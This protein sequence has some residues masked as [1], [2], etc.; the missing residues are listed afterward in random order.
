MEN[1]KTLLVEE[2]R[3]KIIKI[4]SRRILFLVAM[5]VVIFVTMGYSFTVGTANLTPRESYEVLLGQLFPDHFPEYPP[6]YI[7][8]MMNLR[9]PRVL[10]GALVGAI[11][12]IGGCIMQSILKN[13]LATPYT[14]G[15]SSGAAVGASIYF[16]FGIS[17]FGGHA[18]LISN[19]FFFSLLP[20]C[21]MMFVLLRRT[22]SAVTLVLSGVAFSYVFSSANS[23]MQYFG[24][25]SAVAQVVFWTIGDLTSS[26]MWMVPVLFVG[27]V[28]YLAITW[29]LG[30]DMD[31]MRM[32]DDTAASLGINVNLVRGLA[33]VVACFMTALA[34]ACAGPIGFVCLLAPHI[35]RR[36]VGSELRWLVPTAACFGSILLLVSD[37]IAKTVLAPQMLPVGAVTALIGAPIMVYML[38]SKRGMRS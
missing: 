10:V 5:V 16:I 7:F 31:I 11:L 25:D 21:A 17:I 18:G 34:V 22:V 15:V 24:D 35:C 38:Y 36:L 26:D 1:D 33:L 27:L 9:A 3:D 13:P 29:Y 19:A 12:G 4:K 6:N 30:K 23:I 32:G 28:A 2:E 37:M 20:V 8:I 14:L